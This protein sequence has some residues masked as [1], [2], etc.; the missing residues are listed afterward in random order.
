MRCSAVVAAIAVVCAVGCTSKSK[1]PPPVAVGDAT[2]ATTGSPEPEPSSSASS[3][4]GSAASAASAASAG[5]AASIAPS[6]SASG[7]DDPAAKAALTARA[8]KAA[9]AAYDA[10]YV[11]ATGGTTGTVRIVAAPPRYRVDLVS[12]ARTAEFYQIAIGAV[13]CTVPAG[14]SAE[15]ALVAKP[16]QPIPDAV[17]PGV[18]HLFTDGLDALARHPEGFAV[19][20]LPDASPLPGLAPGQCFHIERLADLAP[21][22]PGTVPAPGEGFESGDYCFDPASGVLTSVRV[23]TGTLT[24]QKPPAAPVDADFTPPATPQQLS[25]SAS[26]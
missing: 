24:L 2:S 5:S 22:S 11:F 14:K 21:V 20:A 9:G 6:P 15:C 8:K 19:A 4:A 3:S 7:T 13:N 18:Q 1:E 12:G 23:A 10:T 17:D 25:A 26:P 16:G